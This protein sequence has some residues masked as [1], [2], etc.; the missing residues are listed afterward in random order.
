MDFHILTITQSLVS[1]AKFGSYH[2]GMCSHYQAI[3]ERE[4]YARHFGVESPIEIGKHDVWPG[5]ASTFIRRPTESDVG[6]EAVPEREAMPG[7]FGLIPHWSTDATIGRRTFNARSET[8][9]SKPSFREAWKKGS[10]CV[11]PLD[12]FFEPDWRTGKAIPTRIARADGQPMGIAGLWSAWKSP[13][14]LVHTVTGGRYV[15]R[16]DTFLAVLALGTAPLAALAQQVGRVPR[17]GFLAN[18]FATASPSVDAFRKGLRDFGYVE[19]ENIALEIRWAEGRFERMPELALELVRWKPDLLVAVV[20]QGLQA[21]RAATKSIPVVVIACDPAESVVVNIAR[22]SG[23]IT[24]VTCM[25]SDL[26]PKRLQLLKE[27]APKIHRVA[28]LY[29]SF[30]PNKAEEVRQMHDVARALGLGLLPVEV[31]EVGAIESALASA[32]RARADA[33]LVLNDPLLYQARR[34]IV[35]LAAKHRLPATY[36]FKEYVEAGGLM[37]YGT[38]QNDLFRRAAS[39]VNKVLKGAKPADLPVEQAMLFE[40]V[41]NLKTARALGLQISST[42][43]TRTDIVIE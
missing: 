31:G 36:A 15:N 43:L 18:G 1:I 20:P 12:V 4:R 11:I 27:V 5:Y 33:L 10:H 16:R 35:E 3:K 13:K 29:N 34:S 9:A 21:V 37:S 38:M 32:T 23:N 24:G 25:A 14:G 2:E 17:V 26:T 30:D 28:V 39:H 41:I 7:L 6:D 19:G 22:P 40:L 8:V 42:F